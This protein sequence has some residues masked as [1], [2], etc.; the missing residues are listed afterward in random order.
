MVVEISTVDSCVLPFEILV[1][2]KICYLFVN[3]RNGIWIIGLDLEDSARKTHQRP[4]VA[5][6]QGID[7]H[8]NSQQ[9]RY[10]VG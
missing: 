8:R 1:E 7:G 4:H 10:G 6:Y 3:S 5:H 9:G 2:S